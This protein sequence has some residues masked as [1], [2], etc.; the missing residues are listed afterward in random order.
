MVEGDPIVPPKRA[1]FRNDALSTGVSQWG[2]STRLFED[3][4]RAIPDSGVPRAPV[5]AREAVYLS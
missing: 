4:S 3:V 5:S 2:R 1:P